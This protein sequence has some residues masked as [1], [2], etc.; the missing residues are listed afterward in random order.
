M[1]VFASC[2]PGNVSC[3]ASNSGLLDELIAFV[4]IALPDVIIVD[5][6]LICGIPLNTLVHVTVTT[7]A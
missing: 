2:A 4:V 5:F 1:A 7:F 3:F 6:P